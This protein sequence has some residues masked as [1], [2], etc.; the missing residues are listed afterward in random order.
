MST[1]E[2]PAAERPASRRAAAPMPKAASGIPG[3]DEIL[4]GGL[5]RGRATLV[6]GG[7]GCGKTLLATHFL[8]HGA[9]SGEPGVFF[10]FEESA[11]EIVQNAASLGLDL[12]SLRRD[13]RLL[14]QHLPVAPHQV[15]EIG[16]YDLSG[17][18]AQLGHAIDEI[19]A[20]RVVLDTLETLFARLS[21][22]RVVRAE[23]SRLLRTLKERG[24][25]VVV[26]AEGGAGAL[27]RHGLEEYVSDCV[28]LLDN[29]VQDEICTRRLRIVKC[30]G[31]AHGSDEYPFLISS[32]GV[33]VLPVSSVGLEY[34]V[35]EQRVSSGITELDAML[36]GRGYYRGSMI[37]LTGTAGTGK[38]SIA[39]HFA[40]AACGRGE[41]AL[42]VSAEES[43]S[44]LSRNMRSIGIDL[45]R[46]Q[47]RG[48]LRI[49]A[50]R[51][52]RY[53]LEA[54]LEALYS[55]VREFEPQVLVHDPISGFG[56]LGSQFQIKSMLIRLLDHLRKAGVTTLLTDLT[57][58]DAPAEA[59]DTAISS[60]ADTWITLRNVELGSERPRLLHIVKS[61]GMAH[62]RQ[63]R[64]YELTAAGLRILEE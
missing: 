45:D 36:E 44:Q 20:K 18:L 27:T 38:S 16:S 24:V 53:G 34:G 43:A 62:S 33:S 25:T 5:P 42:Y 15:L 51:T 47:E 54:H 14:L 57:G 7:P 63:T 23:L 3:L 26:T 56:S 10:S 41:R 12:D 50:V 32:R 35:T 22:Q 64:R 39:A 61:R 30:R 29:R 6:C 21:D 2:Q 13:G 8:V 58:G 31:T 19:G 17:L 46:W 40:D 9:H 52:T 37:L 48:L 28:I 60:V 1:R 49:H 59:T 4:G 55:L 11:A